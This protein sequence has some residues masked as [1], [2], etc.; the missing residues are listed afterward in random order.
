MSQQ[1]SERIAVL[2]GGTSS[3]RAVSLRSG[4]AVLEALLSRGVDAFSIDMGRTALP[5]CSGNSTVLSLLSMA[6]L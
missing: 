1:S 5:S 2:L 4:Q 3:E 6:G